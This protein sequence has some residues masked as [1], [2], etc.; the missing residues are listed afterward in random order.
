MTDVSSPSSASAVAP[1]ILRARQRCMPLLDGIRARIWK[2]CDD[3][4]MIAQIPGE[5]ARLITNVAVKRSGRERARD[6]QVIHLMNDL[7]VA[8]VPECWNKLALRVAKA[9]D[10]TQTS[11]A[12]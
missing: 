1:V 11:H 7:A 12:I 5:H 3:R 10:K 4:E 9:L 2:V 8:Q 6:E